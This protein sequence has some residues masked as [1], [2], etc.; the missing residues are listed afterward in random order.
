MFIP[1]DFEFTN[2]DEIIQ[3]IMQHSFGAVVSHQD[4]KPQAT[5]LPFLIRVEQEKVMLYAHF[6]KMNRQWMQLEEE[7][8]LVIFQGPHAYISPINYHHSNTAPT[9][10]YVAVHALGRVKLITDDAETVELLRQTVQVFEPDGDQLWNDI[11]KDYLMQMAQGV[12]AFR[13][14]VNEFQA[15]RKLSQNKSIEEQQRIVAQLKQSN[16]ALDRELGK[17]MNP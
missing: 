1:K 2:Q 14:E 12:V 4:G 3:F 17:W 9:W 6:A 16:R 8:V 13:L 5:H 15:I 11:P 7:D 10:N